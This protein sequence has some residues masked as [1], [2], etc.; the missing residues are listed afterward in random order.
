MNFKEQINDIRITVNLIFVI[1]V[2]NL[3]YGV[4]S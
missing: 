2:I 4:L 1:T 3:I